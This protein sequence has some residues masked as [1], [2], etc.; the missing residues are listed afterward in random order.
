MPYFLAACVAIY[1]TE[2]F[3]NVAELLDLEN[4][5]T[6]P[7]VCVYVCVDVCPTHSW[8]RSPS[9][10]PSR[11][12]HMCVALRA[13]F[14]IHSS[15]P[16]FRQFQAR[17]NSS[18]TLHTHTHTAHM[19]CATT[20]PL[21]NHQQVNNPHCQEPPRTWDHKKCTST[22]CKRA[23]Y[24]PFGLEFTNN[25]GTECIIDGQPS[26]CSILRVS[27]CIYILSGIFSK[28]IYIY[29]STYS[30]HM[31]IGKCVVV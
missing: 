9:S 28:E 15:S 31:L 13:R 29:T 26:R 27:N 23:I 17:S 16:P 24:A 5:Y 25:I 1:R 7:Y 21:K 8:L 19:W 2:P 3:E 12:A 22:Q 11:S 18:H 4:K 10:L 14:G 30:T 6:H 20:A